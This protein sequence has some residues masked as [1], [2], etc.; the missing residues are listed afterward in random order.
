MCV[1]SFLF[2]NVNM[3]MI[4]YV[5]MNVSLCMYALHA[6]LWAHLPDKESL[7]SVSLFCL[8]PSFSNFRA[9]LFA[10][11]GLPILLCLCDP[12]C[13]VHRVPCAGGSRCCFWWTRWLKR[14]GLD[15]VPNPWQALWPISAVFC[16][17]H[18]TITADVTFLV[19]FPGMVVV[20]PV[21]YWWCAWRTV[22]KNQMILEDVWR[23]GMRDIEGHWRTDLISAANSSMVTRGCFQPCE[24]W[25]CCR[26]SCLRRLR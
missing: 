19:S 2:V 9:H 26:Q 14:L 4:V 10:Y 8:F 22:L 18:V 23:K 1:S 5:F 20:H 13:L 12:K 3:F 25:S 15:L 7:V 11:L 24:R 6:S 16:I 21:I 17:R